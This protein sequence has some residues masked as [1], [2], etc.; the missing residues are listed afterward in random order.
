MTK[1][2]IQ[3][4]NSYRTARPEP[5]NNFIKLSPDQV[6]TEPIEKPVVLANPLVAVVIKSP[7][8]SNNMLNSF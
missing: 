4:L 5:I 6:T 2:T 1:A 8:L 7:I 3:Y